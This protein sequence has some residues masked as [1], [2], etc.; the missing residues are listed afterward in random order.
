LQMAV[1]YAPF[2]QSLFKTVSLSPGELTISLALST[3]VFWGVELEKRLLRR[4]AA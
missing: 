2:M 1:V 3:V 4:G